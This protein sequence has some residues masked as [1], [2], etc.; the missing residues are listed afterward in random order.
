MNDSNEDGTAK[1]PKPNRTNCLR[2]RVAV[3]GLAAA[4]HL[5]KPPFGCSQA[6]LP[7]NPLRLPHN[8]GSFLADR[9]TL[10]F[11]AVVP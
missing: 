6:R 7:Q 4:V 1:M 5:P 11:M 9:K 8:F 10:I 2:I 3:R